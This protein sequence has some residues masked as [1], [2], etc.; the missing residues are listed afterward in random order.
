MAVRKSILVCPPPRRR[1]AQVDQ[2]RRKRSGRFG[3]PSEDD[4]EDARDAA[5]EDRRADGRSCDIVRVACPRRAK[6][7]EA[8]T[9]AVAYPRYHDI[10]RRSTSSRR[11]RPAGAVRVNPGNIRK[12]DD[13]WATSRKSPPI[14]VSPRIG[15]NAEPAESRACSRSTVVPRPRRWLSPRFG[16]PQF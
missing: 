8:F 7:A 15:V 14:T 4:D 10:H 6:D 2:L 5:A 9:P 3:C 16:R 13:R 11:L 12:F 1:S